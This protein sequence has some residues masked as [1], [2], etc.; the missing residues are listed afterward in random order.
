VDHRFSAQK[1]VEDIIKVYN[2]LLEVKNID[3]TD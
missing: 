2:E 1:M 3:Y